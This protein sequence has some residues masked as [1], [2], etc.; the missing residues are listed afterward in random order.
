V[1]TE[2]YAKTGNPNGKG[3]PNWPLYD[4]QKE[5]ILD[6]DLDG[7][8]VAKPDPRKARFNVIEQALIR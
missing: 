3:M 5:E 1:S 4:N 8:V 2:R 6:I 7:K